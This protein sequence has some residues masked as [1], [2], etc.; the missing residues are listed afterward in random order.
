V[1]P[2]TPVLPSSGTV[3][4]G[5]THGGNVATGTAGDALTWLVERLPGRVRRVV[6]REL[7]GFLIL[8]GF[9]FLVDL[10]LLAAL[11]HWTKLPL[12]VAVSVAYLSAFGLNFVLN[13][14]VNFRSHAPVG[15]QA[16]RYAIVIA[17]DYLLTLGVTTGLSAGGLDFRIARL[18]AAACVAVFTYTASRWWVF[19]D[20]VR[21]TSTSSATVNAA[22]SSPA[23]ASA[24][25][26]AGAPATSNTNP[27]SSALTT[28]AAILQS[29]P[30]TKS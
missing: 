19:R 26:A 20:P 17:A 7:V 30:M 2:L 23:V 21:R 11:R 15:A 10:A 22:P 27:T 12:P 14:T 28:P 8:G 24:T 13:R 1:N 5:R 9:T 29:S 4:R 25:S 18:I 6:P 16:I 3:R